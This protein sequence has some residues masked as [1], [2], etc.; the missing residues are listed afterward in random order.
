VVTGTGEFEVN[1]KKDRL[2]TLQ[3]KIE[4]HEKHIKKTN[5]ALAQ[6]NEQA[7]EQLAALRVDA[8]K[9]E[10]ARHRA[11]QLAAAAGRNL[12]SYVASLKALPDDEAFGRTANNFGG[13][14]ASL[15]KTKGTGA[16]K[17]PRGAEPKRKSS[18]TGKDAKPA[19][20]KAPR[21]KSR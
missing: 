2:E 9:N 21:A 19:S 12:D 20:K 8:E 15:D 7:E 11:E 5:V 14:T 10:K 1:G 3:Q 13:P 4:R 18:K 17:T 6:F 16:K